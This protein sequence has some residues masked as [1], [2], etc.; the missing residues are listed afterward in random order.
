MRE[1][2]RICRRFRNAYFQYMT[3]NA[4][5]T[6]K[7]SNFSFKLTPHNIRDKKI[8]I[9]KICQ[10][11]NKFQIISFL[12]KMR[13]S[14][15]QIL[16]RKTYG[17]KYQKHSH[18]NQYDHNYNSHILGYISQNRVEIKQ[19]KCKIVVSIAKNHKMRTYP[20]ACSITTKCILEKSLLKIQIKNICK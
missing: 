18:T 19:S 1:S 8:K 7:N 11:K 20:I 10:S 4:Q 13:I 6:S 3:L 16:N 2:C 5:F 17:V 12:Y 15:A 9:P 14:H